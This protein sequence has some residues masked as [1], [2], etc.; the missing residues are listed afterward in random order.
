MDQITRDTGSKGM[1]RRSFLKTTLAAGGV[2]LLV[3]LDGLS[4]AAA[5]CDTPITGQGWPSVDGWEHRTIMHF[6][7]TIY[8]GNHGQPLFAGD[9]YPLKSNGDTSAGA[10]AACALDVFYDPYYGVAGLK[11]NALA[12]VL[13]W[14]VRF[15]GSATYFYNATL[16]QQLRAVDSLTDAQW[17]GSGFR[18]AATL[19]FGGVLGAFENTQ[20]TTAIGWPGPNG[21]YYDG[22]K[23][24]ANAWRQPARMTL[25]GNMP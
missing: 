16:A 21:G 25:D 11:S 2:V 5:A 14:T 18:D 3:N 7:N 1:S 12:S 13:D 20:V 4:I 23:H 22:G 6:L 24:P 15:Q 8:P 10:Y 17:I 19:G 9:P